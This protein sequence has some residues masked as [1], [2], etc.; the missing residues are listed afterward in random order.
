MMEKSTNSK[1]PVAAAKTVSVLFHPLLIP[2]YGLLVIFTA[3]T[4]FW[5][6]PI[7]AK[8][9]LFVTLLVNNVFIPIS[10]MVFFRYRNLISSSILENRAQR[11]LPLTAATLLFAVTSFI[12][13]RLQIPIFFKTYVYSLTMLSLTIL[14]INNWWKISIYSAGAGTLVSVVLMLSIRMS[15]SLPVYLAGS[16]LIA[17]LILSSRLRLD[18]HNPSEVYSG[19]LA[20]LIIPAIMIL[21]FQ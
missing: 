6:I 8:E 4:L 5:Y 14:V 16:I 3:P 15:A 12:L 7:R 17:G 13:S 20:G 18:S 9:M 21:L 11:T 1:I 2:L 19:F 10:L